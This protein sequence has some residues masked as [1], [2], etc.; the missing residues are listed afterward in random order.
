LASKEIILFYVLGW[1]LL[2]GLAVLFAVL[3]WRAVGEVNHLACFIGFMLL[4]DELRAGHKQWFENWIQES[5]EAN[6][7]ALSTHAIRTIVNLA[8]RWAAGDP[9][10]GGRG[11]SVLGFHALVWNQ[12]K[13]LEKTNPGN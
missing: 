13:A 2:G 7:Q 3:Y 11:S 8:N 1:I 10:Q 12:K 5:A 6:A 4:H 9:S